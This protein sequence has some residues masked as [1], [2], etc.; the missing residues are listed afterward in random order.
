MVSLYTLAPGFASRLAARANR[1]RDLNCAT[2]QRRAY[3]GK[4]FRKRERQGE[5]VGEGGGGRVELSGSKQRR[6]CAPATT[7]ALLLFSLTQLPSTL[8]RTPPRPCLPFP[9][10]PST[11]SY[12][13]DPPPSYYGKPRASLA[14]LRLSSPPC[15]L[16]S[17]PSSHALSR[18]LGPGATQCMYRHR[19]RCHI[20]S[21]IRPVR[22]TLASLP[23]RLTSKR[24][25]SSVRSRG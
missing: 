15:A 3:R 2:N 4:D 5:E 19:C 21:S 13:A 1:A 7:L 20:P 10:R 9:P 25:V 18:S 24:R 23:R 14:S 11:K 17:S 16:L 22:L 6:A 12:P 8:D